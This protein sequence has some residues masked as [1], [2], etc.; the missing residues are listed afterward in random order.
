MLRCGFSPVLDVL[1]V[2]LY[3][4]LVLLH[5]SNMAVTFEKKKEIFFCSR[6]LALSHRRHMCV[7]CKYLNFP[8]NL[9]YPMQEV[10]GMVRASFFRISPRVLCYP[11]SVMLI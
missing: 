6:V 1:E 5:L 7:L 11:F 9:S 8:N 4:V 2:Y 10:E 3:F